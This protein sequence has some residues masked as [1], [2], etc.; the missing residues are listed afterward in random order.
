MM[1]TNRF[2]MA[3]VVAFGLTACGGGNASKQS[4]QAEG[5]VSKKKKKKIS[6]AVIQH[7]QQV[8]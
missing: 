3:V 2:F 1:K 5:E 6:Y 7:F 4:E 8:E